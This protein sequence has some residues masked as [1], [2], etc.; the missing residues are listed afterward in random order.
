ML[1]ML[2][3]LENLDAE[4]R[5]DTP[6]KY[7]PEGDGNFVNVGTVAWVKPL[8][9]LDGA[10]LHR[11]NHVNQ[12]VSDGLCHFTANCQQ[13]S[14]SP[15]IWRVSTELTFPEFDLQVATP[16]STSAEIRVRESDYWETDYQQGTVYHNRVRSPQNRWENTSDNNKPF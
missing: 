11:K 3:Q 2:L 9:C 13:N 4:T 16:E 5:H 7:N 12:P 1:K 6:G 15:L 8:A 14:A 10:P